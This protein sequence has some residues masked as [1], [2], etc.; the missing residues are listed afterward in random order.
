MEFCYAGYAEASVLESER[1]I[2]YPAGG[3]MSTDSLSVSRSADGTIT[4]EYM[5]IAL[6][7]GYSEL[8][9]TLVKNELASENVKVFVEVTKTTLTSVPEENN[10]MVGNVEGTSV[11]YVDGSVISNDQFDSF[12]SSVK[13]ALEKK[14]LY[15]TAQIIFLKADVFKYLTDYNYTDYLDSEYYTERKSISIQK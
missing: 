7:A 15:G 6:R 11:I 10:Q 4:D 5:N 3:I 1:L 14:Q 13:Q 2:A 9:L 12:V 8:V